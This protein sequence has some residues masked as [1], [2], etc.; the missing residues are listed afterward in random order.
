MD[1]VLDLALDLVLVVVGILCWDSE[2]SW[3]Q[4]QTMST[5]LRCG[6]NRRV[7][8]G[9]VT[10]GRVNEGVSDVRRQLA[11]GTNNDDTAEGEW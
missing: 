5:L 2:D 3:L 6:K 1:L 11:P 7:M 4:G 8:R 10:S 9:I